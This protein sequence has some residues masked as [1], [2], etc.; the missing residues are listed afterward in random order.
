M[1]AIQQYPDIIDSSSCIL[2]I[3]SVVDLSLILF[4]MSRGIYSIPRESKYTAVFLSINNKTQCIPLTFLLSI[5][6][7]YAPSF[8]L[9]KLFL[10]KIPL[11][12]RL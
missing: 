8:I 3:L 4:N 10:E 2:N 1:K 12:L 7:A 11:H 5:F 9:G 6:M